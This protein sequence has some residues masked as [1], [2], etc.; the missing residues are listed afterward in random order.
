M[1][2]TPAEPEGYEVRVSAGTLLV[3]DDAFFVVPHVWTE[4]GV[5]V[6]GGTSGA[7]LLHTAVATCVLND[8][9]RE[10]KALGLVVDGVTVRA[11]GGFDADWVSTGVTYTLG[12]DSPEDELA[13]AELRARV[14]EVAEVP[15]AVRAGAAVT[16]HG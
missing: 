3:R 2:D 6:E 14:D 15:K 5:A 8:T 4:T 11:S 16:S 1:A 7:H 9:F 10:A 12:L 13:L